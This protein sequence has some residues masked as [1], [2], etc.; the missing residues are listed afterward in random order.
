[1]SIRQKSL[2]TVPTLRQR[3]RSQM[4]IDV[5]ASAFPNR[6][7]RHVEIAP[8]GG[9]ARIARALG[10]VSAIMAAA[11][12][13]LVV[14]AIH[15]GR[16][17]RDSATDIVN[18]LHTVNDYFDKRADFTAPQRAHAELAE[19]ASVLGDLDRATA[20]NADRVAVML[21]DAKNLVAA[22][23]GDVDIAHQLRDITGALAG[24][25]QQINATAGSA[26]A[27]VAQIDTD[28]GRAI[29]LVDQLNAELKRTTDKLAPLPAQGALIPAPGGQR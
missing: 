3:A 24:A 16:E 22:G 28:L 2:A 9:F 18:N 4:R 20:Q 17:V 26:D 5:P 13:V 1:M 10:W 6:R 7:L 23:S 15:K 11:L 8:Q 29:D 14:T 21:P 27:T 19:L 12:L 25:A